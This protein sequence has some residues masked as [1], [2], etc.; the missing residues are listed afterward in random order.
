MEHD[1][2]IKR[3]NDLLGVE[4]D[5]VRGYET[6]IKN[7]DDED[8]VANLTSFQGDHENHLSYLTERIKQEGGKPKERPDIKGPFQQGMTAIM[9]KMGDKNTLR[10]MHQNENVTNRT[11]D[12]AVKEDFPADI[13]EKLKMFQADEHRHRAWIEDKLDE[14]GER[15][16]SRKESE[17]RPGAQP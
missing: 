11:Y 14:L 4:H 5:A 2:L 15:L 17:E 3:L 7:T 8:I 1:K 10:V 9:S 16:T 12:D 6:A 13:M